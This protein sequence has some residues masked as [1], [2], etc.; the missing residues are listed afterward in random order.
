MSDNSTGC[1]GIG[2]RN[3]RAK[4]NSA[5]VFTW[6]KSTDGTGYFAPYDDLDSY[7]LYIDVSHTHTFSGNTVSTQPTFSGTAGTTGSTTPTFTGTAGT[8]SSNGS[9]SSFS[10][11]PPYVVK[12][13]WERTA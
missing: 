10:I 6:K 4:M 12:Y 2:D 9:G 5:G 13:C 7:T 11:L 3:E 1:A 8:T